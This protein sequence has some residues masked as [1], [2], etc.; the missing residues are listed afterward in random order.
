[1]KLKLLFFLTLLTVGNAFSQ[2]TGNFNLRVPEGTY[3]GSVTMVSDEFT[4]EGTTFKIQALVT[5]SSLLATPSIVSN[6]NDRWGVDNATFDGHLAESAVINSLSIVDFNDNGTGYTASAIS[7]FYF[8]A[9]IIRGADGQALDSPK[10][11][12]DGTT[13]PGVFEIG[14]TNNTNETISFG[15]PYTNS[16]P[17]TITVGGTTDV[18]SITLATTNNSFR[19]S[20]QI[21][22]TEVEFVFSGTTLTGNNSS[23]WTE[24]LNWSN[25]VP[26]ASSDVIIPSGLTNQPVIG[27]STG[28][29]TNNLSVDGA[30]TLTI[31]HGGSLI[32]NGTSTGNITYNVNVAD[33]NWHL[34]SS[35]V[36]GAVYNDTWVT[37]ND[38]ASGSDFTTNRGI[39]TYDNTGS[40]FPHIA[41]EG[42][43]WR[44]TQGGDSGTFGSGVGYA[45]I[46]D[47]NPGVSSGNYSFT[48]TVPTADVTPAISQSV[49]NW[50][51]VANPFPSY[52]KISDLVSNN[53]TNLSVANQAIYVWNGTTYTSTTTTDYVHPGQAFF[54]NSNVN[55]TLSIA[56]GLQSHQTGVTYYRTSNNDITLDIS[57]SDESKFRTTKVSYLENK[58][59][60]LDSGFDIGLF[61]GVSSELSLYTKLVED[62]QGVKFE[63]QALDVLDIENAIIPLGVKALAG[64]EI[65]FTVS[66]SNFPSDVKVYLEDRTT[67]TFTQLDENSNFKITPEVALTGT[68][69]FYIHTTESSLSIS[70]DAILN[71]VSIFKTDASTIRIAGLA[72]GNASVKLFNILGKQVMDVSFNSN[73]VKDIALPKLSTGVYIVQLQTETGKL[74]KKIILE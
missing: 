69:R 54:I 8:K 24:P 72:Q 74:N 7:A 66:K 14:K 58:T 12:V 11:T 59:K 22:G 15:V 67:N 6:T 33:T 2:T 18:T 16:V 38:I 62:Y 64:K 39:S 13:N 41:G 43:H 68:G 32:V 57:L 35:P 28:A 47:A 42:G 53:T 36:V 29:V 60:G 44:Y 20:W 45:L 30:S 19:N 50:N 49:N 55:G 37:D 63:K 65:T 26:T 34:V 48:G 4:V 70:N 17:E 71:S 10:I 46:K 21:I 5:P 61:D 40:T 31:T 52:I 51:L 56:E 3:T 25:G 23:V 1:M 27:S 9:I 73:G